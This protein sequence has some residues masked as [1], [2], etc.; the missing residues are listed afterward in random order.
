MSTAWAEP[1][2]RDHTIVI[3]ALPTNYGGLCVCVCVCE[4]TQSTS[5]FFI[6]TIRSCGGSWVI[7]GG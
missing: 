1:L 5:I 6:F 7:N 4:T 2:N 3:I